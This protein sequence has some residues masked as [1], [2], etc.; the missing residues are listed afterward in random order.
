M[1]QSKDIYGEVDFLDTKFVLRYLLIFTIVLVAGWIGKDVTVILIFTLILYYCLGK[2]LFL[3]LNIWLIWFFTQGFYVGQNFIHNSVISNY[4]SKPSFILFIIFLFFLIK[5]PKTILKKLFLISWLVFIFIALESSL[6]NHQMP[7][8]IIT[9][10]AFFFLYLLLTSSEITRIQ[11]QKLLNLFVSVAILQTFV[12][13]LQVLQILPPAS[14]LMNDGFGGIELW[15]AALDDAA[16]GTF[17]ADSSHLVSWYVAMISLFAIL[18]WVLTRRS[19]YIVVVIISLAQFATVDSKTVMVVMAV[20]MLY[21]LCYLYKNRFSFILTVS[22]F[23]KIISIAAFL[24]FGL[25]I[26]WNIYYENT[27]SKYGNGERGDIQAVY[28]NEVSVSFNAITEHWTEWGK[29][30]GFRYVFDD[31]LNDPIQIIGGYGLQG[32]DYNGKM[33]Y[34]ESQD[35]PIMQS[36][37]STRSRS[38][39]IGLFAS[40]GLVGICL[41]FLS[42]FDWYRF[43]LSWSDLNSK[44]QKDKGIIL[45]TMSMVKIFSFFSL[46]L[47]FLYS[48]DLTSIPIIS[49]AG[50]VAVLQG[51]SQLTDINPELN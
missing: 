45:L 25:L 33:K 37:D 38:G 22:N 11:Y 19:K 26:A 3:A 46:L 30:Q 21:L 43:N 2:K 41:I 32:Y 12:S 20:M 16:S 42:L 14:K 29:I 8:V 47:A 13:L 35:T 24:A 17:G 18:V 50:L 9:V 49:F 48:F 31:F 10:S 6:Y 39:M 28:K 7:F 44:E 5:I 27:N 51:Y 1:Q 36:D 40:T 34:I 4:I 15:K 23:F